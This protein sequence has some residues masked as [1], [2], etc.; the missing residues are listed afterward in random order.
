MRSAVWL[1]DA[2][3]DGLAAALA[4][5]GVTVE[6]VDPDAVESAALALYD[7]GGL[8][9]LDARTER[10]RAAL[11]T[12]GSALVAVLAVADAAEPLP[13]GVL[14]LGP[15]AP[16][17]MA[18]HVVEVLRAP[19]DLRR[20]PRVPVGLPVTL[21]VRPGRAGAG[22]DARSPTDGRTRDDGAARSD[23]ATTPSGG[24]GR[25]ATA[26]AG[27][28]THRPSVTDAASAGPTLGAGVP[29]AGRPSAVTDPERVAATTLDISLYGLRCAPAGALADGAA[30]D[31]TVAL[32]DGAQIHLAG[33]VVDRRGDTVALRCRP[34]TDADL[35]LWVHLLI[36]E[37]EKSPLHAELDPFGPLFA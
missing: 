4:A 5:R 37:L 12:H 35:L 9:V 1:L 34:A 30:V 32:G 25:P 36:G 6:R 24:P 8:L 18:H 11:A 13:P 16:E 15:A 21:V 23:A 19:D 29:V 27:P 20:H 33:V 17:S 14:R 31:A 28:A 3:L 2:G 26:T 7:G 22:I 10:G